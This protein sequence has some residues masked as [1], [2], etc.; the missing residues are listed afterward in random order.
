[1]LESLVAERGGE[2]QLRMKAKYIGILCCFMG[3]LCIAVVPLWYWI[4]NPELSQMQVFLA[5]WKDIGIGLISGI[6]GIIILDK[7]Q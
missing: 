1:M 4:A 3:F 2:K 7:S 6:I 5:R